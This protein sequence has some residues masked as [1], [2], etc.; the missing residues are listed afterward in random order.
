M[1]DGTPEA[2]EGELADVVVGSRRPFIEGDEVRTSRT[3]VRTASARTL[4]AAAE[5]SVTSKATHVAFRIERDTVFAPQIRYRRK[6][7]TATEPSLNGSVRRPRL[8]KPTFV[9]CN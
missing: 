1:T 6:Y 7:A 5:T 2:Y 9:A 3:C 4:L 8:V